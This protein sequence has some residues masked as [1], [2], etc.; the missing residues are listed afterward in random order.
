MHRGHR[1]RLKRKFINGGGVDFNDHEILE[2]LLYYSIPRR[3]T[4]EAAHE[5]LNEFGNLENILNADVQE[6]AKVDGIGENSAVLLKL[7]TAL[8]KRQP[9]SDESSPRK[10]LNV[11]QASACAR[12]IFTACQKEILFA[13]FMDDTMNV[14]GMERLCMGT[15]NEIRP[16]VRNLIEKSVS[17]HATTIIIFHNH[18]SGDAIAS[19]SDVNFTTLLYR[20]LKIVGID[21]VEHLIISNNGCEP[22][23]KNMREQAIIP[24]RNDLEEFYNSPDRKS[25]K[26]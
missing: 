22:L 24:S 17:N 25:V 16:I 23:M 15:D 11:E 14:L 18:P 21:L 20:E 13:V 7:I 19:Q 2:L 1:T 3:N 26:K 4:N 10:L 12:Q 6:I 5:L 8:A 9:F